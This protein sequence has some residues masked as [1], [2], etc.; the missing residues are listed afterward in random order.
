M[1]FGK[2]PRLYQSPGEGYLYAGTTD[3]KCLMLPTPESNGKLPYIIDFKTGSPLKGDAKKNGYGEWPMQTASYRNASNGVQGNGIVHLSKEDGAMSWFDYSDSYIADLEAFEF[4]CRYWRNRNAKVLEEK[5]GL[6]S[7]TTI[8][9]AL[10]K[11]ALIWWAVNSMRDYLYNALDG[12]DDTIEYHPDKDGVQIIRLSV[13]HPLIEAARKNFRKVGKKAMDIGTQV[14]EAIE[15]WF[16]TGVE[17]PKNAPDEV[18]ASFVAFLDWV[19]LHQVEAI[20]VEKIVYGK[21]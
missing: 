16:K 11:P 20:E 17:P 19:D 15:L 1:S 18:T 3:L 5:G 6:P 4:L 21:F 10:D 7:S 8:L 13:L 9:G 14:H 2:S 12:A